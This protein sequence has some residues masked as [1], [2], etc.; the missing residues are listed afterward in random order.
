MNN[1]IKNILA[2]ALATSVAISGDSTIN[3][4]N[5]TNKSFNV[6]SSILEPI[7]ILKA[8][9]DKI[10]PI[11]VEQEV[12][13]EV[14]EEVV[15]TVEPTKEEIAEEEYY[16]ELELLACV[17]YCEARGE[18]RNGD[19][20]VEGMRRVASVVLNRV[21]SDEFPDTIEGVITQS[22]QFACYPYPVLSC[23]PSKYAYKA[24]KLELEEQID[25][26]SLYFSRAQVGG[27]T[28]NYTYLNHVF[29]Y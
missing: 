10:E 14:E 3:V 1:F 8:K 18:E 17:V 15:E 13:E 26:K 24:V 7:E 11:K 25:T 16:G 21:K 4:E 5:A 19:H 6:D 27:T 23:D 12:E 29:S 28:Y 2:L 20:G 22:G 9:T